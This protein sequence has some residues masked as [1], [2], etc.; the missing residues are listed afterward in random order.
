M[1]ELAS[2]LSLLKHMPVSDLGKHLS[3]ICK[4]QPDLTEELLEEQDQPLKVRKCE[5]TG[6]DYI[7]CDHNRDGD[8]FRSPWSNNYYP[9]YDGMKPSDRL[10][11]LEMSANSLFD[12]YCSSY[13]DTAV[14]SV[15]LWDLDTG[16]AGAVLINKQIKDSEEM[17][18]GG[19]DS[20][21]VIEAEEQQDGQCEYTLTTTVM[22]YIRGDTTKSFKLNMSGMVNVQ[23]SKK[24]KATN[25]DDHLLHIGNLIQNTENRIRTSLDQVYFGKALEITTEV[26]SKQALSSQKT[27]MSVNEQLAAKFAQMNKGA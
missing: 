8:S 5:E 13:Y 23:N 4:L 2:A 21:H 22:L 18:L 16:F 27:Q 25:D 1:T 17:A 11:K 6:R 19:W 15:F 24:E 12:S 7:I 26:R 9:E 14:S 20:I 3:A 10:R